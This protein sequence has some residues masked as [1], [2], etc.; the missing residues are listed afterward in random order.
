MSHTGGAS[1]RKATHVCPHVHRVAL[2]SVN[3]LLRSAPLLQLGLDLGERRMTCGRDGARRVNPERAPGQGVPT[4]ATQ[5]VHAAG[6]SR[7][8]ARVC[9]AAGEAAGVH[10]SRKTAPPTTA[11]LRAEA[12]S[13]GQTPRGAPRRFGPP[14]RSAPSTC[15]WRARNRPSKKQWLASA[16]TG[17]HA[18]NQDKPRQNAYSPAR[19]V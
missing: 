4:R 5:P 16:R 8:R 13:G 17:T 7:G 11:P 10:Q 1:C 3:R 19:L 15:R 9:R 6:A 2:D 18:N 12:P 14:R